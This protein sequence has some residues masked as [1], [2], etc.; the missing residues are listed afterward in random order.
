MSKIVSIVQLTMACVWVLGLMLFSPEFS[1]TGIFSSWASTCTKLLAPLS[2]P[3]WVFS[4]LS[5]IP[6]ADTFGA[7]LFLTLAIATY[8]IVSNVAGSFW[9]YVRTLSPF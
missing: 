7:V 9:A 1:I 8:R 3:S 2:L 6:G 5:Y 4:F